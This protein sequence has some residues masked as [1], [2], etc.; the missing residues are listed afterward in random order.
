MWKDECV[1]KNV[2]E[3]TS[4]FSIFYKK[5]DVK[6]PSTAPTPSY[7]MNLHNDETKSAKFQKSI[8]LYNSMFAFTSSGSN[9]DNAIKQGR[10]PYIYQLNSQNHHIFGSLIPDDGDTLKFCQLYIYDTANEVSNRL[11]WV[12]IVD[13]I[14]VN[15][16][17][18]EGLIRMWDELNKLCKEFCMARDWF[19]NNDLVD[20]KF[21]LKIYRSESGKK[22]IFLLLMKLLVLWLVTLQT[23]NLIKNNY[24]T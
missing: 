20:L 14:E 15:V 7:L 21:E 24:S 13:N 4:L 6:L 17:V 18:V 8:R 2:T 1:N 5:G 12:N 22:P 11:R 9:I 23:L 19:E 16:E 3:V 10:G